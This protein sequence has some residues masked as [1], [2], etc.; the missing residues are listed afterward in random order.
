MR[1]E[2]TKNRKAWKR[3]TDRLAKPV[4]NNYQRLFELANLNL[5]ALGASTQI[6]KLLK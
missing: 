4:R 5:Q 6:E 2:D 1:Q 3:T